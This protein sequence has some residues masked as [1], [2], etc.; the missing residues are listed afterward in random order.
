MVNGVGSEVIDVLLDR[1]VERQIEGRAEDLLWAACL[2][3]DE[4]DQALDGEATVRP[5]RTDPGPEEDDPTEPAGAYLRSLT[6][7]G[8]RG[9]ADD[10][11]IELGPGPGLTVIS[12]RNGSGKSSLAEAFEVLL[13]G[14]HAHRLQR[15]QVFQDGWRNLHGDGSGRIHATVHV[16]EHPGT[17]S[18]SRVWHDGDS[19]YELET[20]VSLPGA[21]SGGLDLLGWAEAVELHRPF[22]THS[23][24]ES[25]LA[26]PSDLHD[27][28]ASVLGLDPVVAVRDRVQDARRA[29]DKRRKATT[30]EA[31]RLVEV[32][33]A[34]QDD[35]ATPL[36]EVLAGRTPDPTE[37]RA[38]TVDETSPADSG[39]R[40]VRRW[41]DLSV[42]DEA[43]V[44]QLTEALRAAAG[45]VSE[46]QGTDAEEADR[47]AE[48][49][50]AALEHHGDH[51]DEPC[52]VCGTG[53]LD[54]EWASRTTSEVDRL[55]TEAAAYRDAQRVAERALALVGN[56]TIREVVPVEELAA[57]GVDAAELA[58]AAE[59]LRQ[60]CPSQPIE[61][62][63]SVEELCSSIEVLQ[64]AADEVA[65]ACAQ[66]VT[67]RNDTWAPLAAQV[68]TWCD[69]AERLTTARDDLKALKAVEEWFRAELVALRNER[70]APIADGAQSIWNR[71]RQG[72]NVDL[73][74]LSLASTGN[75]RHVSFSVEV[76]G[77]DGQGLGVMSQGEL[78]S[79][80][81]SVFIP[82]ACVAESPFRF[83]VIDDPVQAMDPAKVAGLA[84]VLADVATTRQV[85][86]FSHDDRL[87][88][89]IRALG[90]PARLLEVSRRNRSR[91][92]VRSVGSRATRS[93]SDARSVATDKNIPPELV[94]RVVPGLAREV[95][96]EVCLDLGRRRL[97]DA[98]RTIDEV[99]EILAR[100][101]NTN[102]KM[103]VALFAD[104]GATADVKGRLGSKGQR[105]VRAYDEIRRGAH[106]AVEQR[107]HDVLNDLEHLVEV[108]GG[109]L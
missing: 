14:R 12:G 53:M 101:D 31:K 107:P 29:L 109:E 92:E 90:L 35:R 93:F 97:L 5:E 89:A 34:A 84:R 11:T 17:T 41:A 38:R 49:L 50:G 6:V 74:D 81:L 56:V 45:R 69:E 28:L 71:L 62:P 79:L 37:V 70:L 24:L 99:D 21:D 23:E 47:L 19:P 105:A 65:Q 85:V 33:E 46:V 106:E 10:V 66:G 30:A 83:L 77:E 43:E 48:L 57:A 8:F 100:A 4:L 58:D 80:A 20:K 91:V 95:L 15:S 88:D 103:A 72:S 68:L 87:P 13:C 26:R 55:R 67:A 59:T 73:Q 86:V 51:G 52:P 22:L 54:G 82:R 94:R 7:G 2:G 25:V 42:L 16:A 63:A 75:R 76:D 1:A 32:L 60:A 98:G 40:V 61:L 108:I 96:E 36:V 3:Q 9:V 64:M 78:N 102:K 27:R 104:V 39:L 44:A 18:L